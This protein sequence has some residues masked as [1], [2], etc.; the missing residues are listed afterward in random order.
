MKWSLRSSPAKNNGG[1]GGSTQKAWELWIVK[2]INE[3]RG[4]MSCFFYIDIFVIADKRDT[5]FLLVSLWQLTHYSSTS[6]QAYSDGQ[7]SGLPE[8]PGPLLTGQDKRKG[9]NK[10]NPKGGE[11]PASRYK[12][13]KKEGEEKQLVHSSTDTLMTQLKQVGSRLKHHIT[14]IGIVTLT[15]PTHTYY[16]N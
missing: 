11:R 10:R 5:A 1:V 9:R 16:L 13:R 12:K 6:S 15:I 7:L 8:F 4:I 2:V 3:Q 14:L